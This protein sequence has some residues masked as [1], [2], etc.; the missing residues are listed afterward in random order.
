MPETIERPDER[1]RTRS[2]ADVPWIVLV[3][4]D[5]VNLMSYVSYVFRS[6]F[7]FGRAEAERLMLQVHTEGRAVVAQGNREEMERHVE[8]MHGYGLWATLQKADA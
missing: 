6:Y 3:W 8:A 2:A 1:L 5:P 4:D 7:G